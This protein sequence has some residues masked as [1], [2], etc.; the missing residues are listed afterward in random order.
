MMGMSVAR[1]G[2]LGIGLVSSILVTR[3]LGPSSRGDLAVS[4]SIVVI[5]VQVGSA[6]LP[7]TNTYLVAREP[8][9]RREMLLRSLRLVFVVAVLVA[10]IGWL[11]WAVGIAPLSEGLMALTLATVPIGVGYSCFQYLWLGLGRPGSFWQMDI[12]NRSVFLALVAGAL[13]AWGSLRTGQVITFSFMALVVVTTCSAVAVAR[14]DDRR[15]AERANEAGGG[16]ELERGY[17][18]ALRT[19]LAS[20]FAYVV[21]RADVLIANALLAPSQVGNYA[22]AVTLVE[23]VIV[24][25]SAVGIVLFGKIA[26]ES[27]EAQ[28]RRLLR[29]S[30]S[31]TAGLS[32]MVGLALAVLS[33]LIVTILYG[34][35]FDEAVGLLRVSAIGLVPFGLTTVA[36]NYL[37]ALGIPRWAVVAWAV[38]AVL[39]V[40]SNM[41]FLQRFGIV[42]AAWTSV[43]T[44]SVLGL[45]LGFGCLRERNPS[46]D[47]LRSVGADEADARVGRYVE[48]E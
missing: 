26:A 2:A 16:S 23:P 34:Q 25:P 18:Y 47:R 27:D 4:S 5:G 20:A 39:N 42:A 48:H 46:A 7:G 31:W 12:G 28:R 6:G 3:A 24:I 13:I 10:V 21:L 35:Q 19:Y 29:Q 11:S 38:G 30:V 8:T 37:G 15:S 36:W 41:V 44:Y 22:A 9:R 40:M 1:V 14:F 43:A 45:W 32:L 33:P 17:G